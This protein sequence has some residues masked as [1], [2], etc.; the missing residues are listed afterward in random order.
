MFQ[1]QQITGFSFDVELV[2]IAS[3]KGYDIGEIPAVVSEQ[4]Q[5]KI[6]KVN[7][8]TDSLVMFL[9]LLRIKYNDK[10]GRYK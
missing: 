3:R 9:D 4:H 2:Y 8:L 1:R 7:L 5:N 6:S 10:I